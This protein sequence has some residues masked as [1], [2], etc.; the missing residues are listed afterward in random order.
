MSILNRVYKKVL[1]WVRF[2]KIAEN[3]WPVVLL[4]LSNMLGLDK[5]STQDAV[6][7]LNNGIKLNFGKQ[8]DLSAV[9]VTVEIWYEKI[10][11]PKGYEIHAGDVVVDIGANVG[12][13]AIFAL[14]EG[15]TAVYAFEPVQKNYELML[16]N[17]EL[18][19]STNLHPFQ[20]AVAGQSGQVVMH[21]S[22]VDT[23]HS[24]THSA[25]SQKGD[26]TVEA[27]TLD[28]FCLDKNIQRIDFLKVDCEGAEYDIF[29]KIS[30]QTLGL[31]KRVGI[32]HHERFVHRDHAEISN[33][34]KQAGFE[35]IEL[36]DHFI[37]GKKHE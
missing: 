23:A 3:F 14:Q 12:N 8:L 16:V 4:R 32:E 6:I 10:Y 15:A 22:E 31:V 36:P 34:L 33:R 13:F 1:L 21:V 19:H 26:V 30:D 9:P 25:F 2:Y 7:K 5:E 28:Q 17:K 27:V 29:E 20:L 35:V 37:F 24:I 18:N 11:S